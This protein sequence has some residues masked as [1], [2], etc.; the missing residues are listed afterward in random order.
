M[1]AQGHLIIS[2]AAKFKV[3]YSIPQNYVLI[4][5]TPAHIWL[6][7]VMCENVLFNYH[8]QEETCGRSC[9]CLEDQSLSLNI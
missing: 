6:Y 3:E 7:K 4:K 1:F 9:L 8:Q 2:K 5:H